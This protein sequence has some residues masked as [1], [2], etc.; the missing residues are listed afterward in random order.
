M[1]LEISWSSAASQIFKA[2]SPHAKL[3]HP[4]A[5]TRIGECP[6]PV[7]FNKLRMNL[8]RA[9]TLFP[10]I[11]NQDSMFQGYGKQKQG[12]EELLPS[13]DLISDED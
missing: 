11:F 2:F 5:G 4:I 6:V 9:M 12:V 7:M 8:R 10:E 1:S 3:L 13:S